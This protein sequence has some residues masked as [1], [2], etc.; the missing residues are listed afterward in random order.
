MQVRP[1]AR[2][3]GSEDQDRS[4]PTSPRPQNYEEKLIGP[5]RCVRGDPA[6]PQRPVM[7]PGARCRDGWRRRGGLRW[8]WWWWSGG[9]LAQRSQEISVGLLSLA[10]SG[11]NNAG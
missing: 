6:R 8:G 11:G 4:A 2:D 10:A 3:Q 1:G 9:L 5:G 7:P